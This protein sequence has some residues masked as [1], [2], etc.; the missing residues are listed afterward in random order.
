MAVDAKTIHNILLFEDMQEDALQKIARL[1]NHMN[2]HEGEI[3][4]QRGEGAHT[5][6]II[7]SG[8]YLVSFSD[9]RAFTL[10][11]K[12]QIMGWSSV[13]S[14]FRY[15]GTAVALTRGEVLYMSSED[16]RELLQGD[17]VISDVLMKKITAVVTERRPYVTGT[18]TVS[19]HL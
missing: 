14:P 1:L 16:F 3:L 12:G 2:V 4:T 10:H 11:E 13:V 19:N 8:N 5:F 6:Y 9:G 17:A 15:S 18:K 7:L